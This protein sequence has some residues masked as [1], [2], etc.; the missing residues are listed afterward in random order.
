MQSSAHPRQQTTWISLGNDE[1][2]DI[3]EILI[4]ATGQ[5]GGG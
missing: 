5:A 4:S 2:I 1:D 3:K